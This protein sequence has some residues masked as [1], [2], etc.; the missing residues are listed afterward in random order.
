MSVLTW[1]LWPLSKLWLCCSTHFLSFMKKSLSII[2]VWP[3][4]WYR[5]SYTCLH[6]FCQPAVWGTHGKPG[7]IRLCIRGRFTAPVLC[8][9]ISST[10]KCEL[11]VHVIRLAFPTFDEMPFINV[12]PILGMS[13]RCV[14]Q[15]STKL[16]C[17]LSRDAINN[18]TEGWA[19]YWECNLGKLSI[20]QQCHE[21]KKWAELP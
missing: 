20:L 5:S 14:Y 16:K 12:C 4:N 1:H 3:V 9:T 10:K 7:S 17:Y 11:H 21:N 6:F 18:C 13:S 2:S 8:H 19:I 15:S